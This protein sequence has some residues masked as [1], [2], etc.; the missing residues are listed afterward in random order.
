MRSRTSQREAQGARHGLAVH[1]TTVYIGSP[2]RVRRY[3]GGLNIENYGMQDQERTFPPSVSQ[4]EVS[5]RPTVSPCPRPRLTEYGFFIDF[6]KAVGYGLRGGYVHAPPPLHPTVGREGVTLPH[7]KTAKKYTV[8]YERLCSSK[9]VSR[10][11]IVRLAR[12]LVEAEGD[13][14]VL[15]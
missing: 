12:V 5:C 2:A 6:Y 15:G 8:L 14:E 10:V 9:P 13:R 4:C 3:A 11:D 1:V 7:A